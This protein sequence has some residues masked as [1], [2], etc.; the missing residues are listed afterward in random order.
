MKRS[1]P[2]IATWSPVDLQK[3]P[4]AD[5]D[6]EDSPEITPETI[7]ALSLDRNPDGKCNCNGS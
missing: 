1:L 4:G 7:L 2:L 6:S 5:N 3:F